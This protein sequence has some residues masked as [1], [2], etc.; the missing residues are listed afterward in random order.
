[1]ADAGDLEHGNIE[2]L[3]VQLL[4]DST[5]K[6][7]NPVNQHQ[8]CIFMISSDFSPRVVSIGPLHR[9]DNNL[10]P[11]EEQKAIYMR[12]LLKRFDGPREDILRRCFQMMNADDNISKIRACYNTMNTY[13]SDDNL[14][15]MMVMDACFILEFLHK[16]S[17]KSP[18][19]DV[20][21]ERSIAYDLLL[22]GNQ[23]PFFVLQDI[24][25]CIN[26]SGE[27]SGCLNSL[28]IVLVNVV[29][30]FQSTL[31]TETL[32]IK[33]DNREY[34]H[35]LDALHQ[36]Y[37]PLHH[38]TP[39]FSL[40]T[41]HSA[42][43]L[44]RRGVNFKPSN[45]SGWPM[46]IILESPSWYFPWAK[47]TLRM[48]KLRIS[49][50]TELILR[51]MI[52]YEQSCRDL[53]CCDYITSYVTAMDLLINNAE[54]VAILAE[55]EVLVNSMGSHEDAAK[56]INELGKEA[57]FTGFVY[58]SQWERLGELYKRYWP[59]HIESFKRS[60]CKSP[61]NMFALIAGIML[62]VLTVLQT[63]YTVN[64]I[65]TK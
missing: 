8:P 24:L 10:L 19:K 33:K 61:W 59:K 16:L 50:D 39:T 56:M 44:D 21:I 7:E 36:C 30:I 62:F 41:P 20:L 18:E 58:L 40:G 4:L 31:D 25:D 46:D 53:G 64:P 55:S 3:N 11:F 2:D 57:P 42:V 34:R 32:D 54:D 28:I 26:S 52:V 22:V 51:N 14:A 38:V 63:Y 15:R 9:N 37:V 65:Q 43:E 23:I 12:D 35:I 1:M 29:N 48:P 49:G 5:Q 13:Y 60:Y 47:S 6:V 17:S 27:N 45:S